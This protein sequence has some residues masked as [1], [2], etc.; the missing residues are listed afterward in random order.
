MANFWLSAK[1]KKGEKQY[2]NWGKLPKEMYESAH[3]NL[4]YKFKLQTKASGLYFAV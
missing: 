1:K 3:M 4:R 2:L